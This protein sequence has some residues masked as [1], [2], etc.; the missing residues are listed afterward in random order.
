MSDFVQFCRAHGVLIDSLPPIGRWVRV[1]TE[2]KPRHRNGAVKWMGDFGFVQNWATM[3]E[4]AYWRGEV[5]TEARMRAVSMRRNAGK[6]AELLAR[7]AAEK[8][9]TILSEC[10]LTTHPYFEKKGFPDHVL[11]VWQDDTA[12]IPMRKGRRLVGLQLID[13]EGGKKFLFGQRSGGA[14]FVFGQK[15][16]HVLCE[17][18]ATAL[19][20]QVVLRNLKLPYQ[21]HVT[22][23]AG[24]MKRI[25]QALPGG[26]VLAD[27]DASGTGERV[28]QEI[29]WPYWMSDAVG[30]DFN[31]AHQRIGTFS[32]AMKLKGVLRRR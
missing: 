22:F 32:L 27:N 11:N 8:A 3:E 1:K 12:V 5:S 4:P 9:A 17:G 31:D 13:E 23:S 25:A 24:N 6:Q 14:E 28:A 15:G 10:E 7:Q 21:I 18:Y 29:G 26:V 16:M 30:E 2:D 20:A 19:S